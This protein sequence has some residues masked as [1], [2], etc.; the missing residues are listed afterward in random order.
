MKPLTLLFF[1]AIALAAQAETVVA[2]GAKLKKLADGFKFAGGPTCDANGNLYFTDQPNDRILKWSV[3]G[4]LSTWMQPAGCVNGM[5]FDARGNLIAC[6]E[7]KNELWSIATNKTVTVLASKFDG[8]IFNAP[9]DVWVAPGGPLYFTDP[10][11]KRNWADTNLTRVSGENVYFFSADR[12]T[13]RP[14]IGDFKKPNGLTG[15]PDGKMLYATDIRDRKTWRY[16]ILPDGSLTNKTRFCG[17]GADGMTIDELGNVYLCATGQTNGVLVFN[18][19]GEMIDR[20][21]VP[22]RW[23]SNVSFGGKD[24]R[25]LFITAGES[26]YAVKLRV[27]G[28][29]PAK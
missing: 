27:K 2:P 20:I 24:H 22:A 6:A 4:K 17:K 13:L 12:R 7:A 21:A 19:A 29:N 23:A 9:N 26:L 11:Y 15:T 1:V 5:M 10:F 25:T 16:D 8:K 14:V 28:G 18:P 3:R